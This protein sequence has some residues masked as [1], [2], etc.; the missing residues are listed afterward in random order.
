MHTGRHG[1][2]FVQRLRIRLQGPVNQ[3]FSCA[4]PRYICLQSLKIYNF[5]VTI[6]ALG[7]AQQ[8]VPERSQSVTCSHLYT[9]AYALGSILSYT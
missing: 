8:G 3:N 1:S 4:T 9:S 5:S 2:K 6:S 7:V